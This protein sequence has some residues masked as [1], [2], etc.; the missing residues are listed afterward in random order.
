MN[1]MVDLL[2]SVLKEELNP[3]HNRLDGIDKR[4]DGIDKRLEGMDKR[5]DGIDKRF[6][7]IDQRLDRLET[8]QTELK[9]GQE[10]LQKNIIES[11]GNFTEKIAEHVDN[12]TSALNKRIF[13]VETEIERL[14]R[15]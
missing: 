1:E 14:T 4:F 13:K 12:Q 6:D 8:N 9:I 3:I 5:F 11:L 10:K 15:Q 7:G 2:R